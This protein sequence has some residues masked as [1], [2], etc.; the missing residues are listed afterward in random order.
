M[1]S[2][3]EELQRLLEGLVLSAAYTPPVL[4]E[5]SLPQSNRYD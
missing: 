4:L 2:Q 3:L 1:H 5:Q